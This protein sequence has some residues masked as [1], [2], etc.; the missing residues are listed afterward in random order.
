M[1]GV[2]E[3]TTKQYDNSLYNPCFQK[4]KQYS[5]E[6]YAMLFSRYQQSEQP[7]LT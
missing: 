4:K 3:Q 2:Y 6:H 1:Y 7:S 5:N